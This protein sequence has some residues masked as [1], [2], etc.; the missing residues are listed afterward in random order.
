MDKISAAK[1]PG[2]WVVEIISF[3]S[4]RTILLLSTENLN[5]NGYTSMNILYRKDWEV[6]RI[7]WTLLCFIWLFFISQLIANMY[8]CRRF[9]IIIWVNRKIRND[10]GGF[11]RNKNFDDRQ[12]NFTELNGHKNCYKRNKS[13]WSSTTWTAI[14]QHHL[15]HNK[16]LPDFVIW[17]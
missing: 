7:W 12:I 13:Y 17:P 14:T 10:F 6:M 2:H 4:K 11:V 3:L 1:C 15:H 16:Q 8:T 9:C 5:E